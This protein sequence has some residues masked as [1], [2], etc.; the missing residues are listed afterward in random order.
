[1]ANPNQ[2]SRNGKGR[3][4]RTLHTA[5]RDAYAAQLRAQHWTYQ[6]IAD[7]LGWDHK[8]SAVTAVRRAL[9][10]ACAGPAKELVEMESARLEAMYD[11][12]LTVLQADHVM[13]SH[14]RVVYDE[15][16]NPLPDYDIKLRA[17]DR[18]LRTR[19]SFRKL[20]GLDQPTKVD[21]RV[22]EVT[23][24]DIEL[25]ELIREAQAKNAVEEA[26]IKGETA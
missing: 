21:A 22:T 26:R 16:G 11:E 12:V 18:A 4:T 19:E 14:G 1:M 10:D 23:Q 8:S 24:Q 7:E 3:Y 17:V 5:E 25:A 13:V 15:H 6:Q 9:R 2:G 20:M